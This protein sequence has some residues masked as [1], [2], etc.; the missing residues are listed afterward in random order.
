[1]TLEGQTEGARELI[2]AIFRL[3]VADYLGHSYSH[4]GNAPA[5][6]TGN[7]FRSEAAT[8]LQSAWAAYLA[9][10]I[11]LESGAIWR[12]ARLLGEAAFVELRQNAAA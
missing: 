2:L 1:V 6:A 4:D 7:R 9:D 12:E 11:G 5:R 10:L 8:F 3:G